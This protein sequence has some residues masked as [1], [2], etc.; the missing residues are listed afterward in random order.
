M[1]DTGSLAIGGALGTVAILLKAEFLLLLIGGVFAAEAISVMLQTGIYKWYKRTRGREYADSPP[2]LPHGAAAPPLREAGLGRDHGGDPVLHPRPLLRPGGALHAEGALTVRGSRCSRRW[3][4][5]GREVAVVGLGKS[6]VAAT[7]LLRAPGLAGVRLGHRDRAGAYDAWAGSAAATPAPT[8]QLGGH[9]LDADRRGRPRSWWRPACRRMCRRSRRPRAAGA[10]RS[11]P[12]WTSG[13]WRSAHPLHRHHRHQ[14]QDHDDVA[15]RPRAGRGRAPRRDGG[16]H[17]PAA[18]R[19]G[20]RGRPAR[21][22]GAGA[23]ARS[24]CTTRRT[25]D[26]AIGVL[27]NLAPNHLDRYRS[28]EEYYGDKAL[29]FRNADADSVWVTN[30][31]D[32]AV[33]AMIGPVAGTGTSGSRSQRGGRLVRSRR[34]AG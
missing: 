17:R 26:P 18:L 15:H 27:T 30:A 28:L 7:L 9:D 24:S 34:P 5:T 23:V 20:A 19:G 10:R 8:V 6:G 4:A 1:G 32:P 29:L 16:Q 11:T 31:D 2:G 14:R 33:Q 25:S 13:S 22:A 12:R 21:L 3:R